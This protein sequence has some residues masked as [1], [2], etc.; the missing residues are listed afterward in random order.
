MCVY[1]CVN[2][3]VR[4][5]LC[6]CLS[7]C[8]QGTICKGSKVKLSPSYKDHSDAAG[9]PLKP[10]DIGTVVED[11]S[12]SKP[13]KV[14][15]D[16]G[17]TWWYRAEALSPVSQGPVLPGRHTGRI[18][19]IAN[20]ISRTDGDDILWASDT[21]KDSG[22]TFENYRDN[23]KSD[24]SHVFEV[25]I[26]RS[27]PVFGALMPFFVHQFQTLQFAKGS[28]WTCC[29]GAYN[30]APC[31]SATGQERELPDNVCRCVGVCECV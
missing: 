25:T 14:K 27:L 30:S 3:R 15:A 28:K 18:G 7:L 20:G 4:V 16:N 1:V 8:V 5:C 9:G 24:L 12:S 31:A 11:D 2:V 6:T 13:Y 23:W 29:G 22:Y 21:T 17:D 19:A 26:L 10:G